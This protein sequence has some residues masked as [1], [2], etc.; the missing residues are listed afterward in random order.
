MEKKII[1][2][3]PVILIL[4][5]VIMI[6]AAKV[7]EARD[8]AENRIAYNEYREQNSSEE[9]EPEPE[10]PMIG[11]L[12]VKTDE[13]DL[14]YPIYTQSEDEK[15]TE[16]Y[17]YKGVVYCTDTDY[18]GTGQTIIMGHN[19][20]LDKELFL[21]LDKLK[22]GDEAKIVIGS[23]EYTYVY[24]DSRIVL[25]EEVGIKTGEALVLMSCYPYGQNT[26]RILAGFTASEKE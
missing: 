3:L 16:D 8:K 25:P 21:H 4:V 1:K 5:G 18:P 11:W 14:K 23:H 10:G 15:V 24:T 9:K 13:L 6:I 22:K 7:N 19:G 20:L 17:L 12:S 26:H 2:F